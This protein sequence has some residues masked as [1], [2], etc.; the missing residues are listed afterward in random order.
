MRN[1]ERL[2]LGEGKDV[3]GRGFATGI[4]IKTCC[5]VVSM[6]VGDEATAVKMDALVVRMKPI[7]EGVDGYA[8]VERR[9][10]KAEW[11][12][13]TTWKFANLDGL[14]NYLG[15][16]G[17][18]AQVAALLEEAEAMVGVGAIHRQNFAYDEM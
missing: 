11:D 18:Q 8:G 10:C 6:N 1:R 14:K 17:K 15:D 2:Y 9:V 16:E 5:R 3:G 4:P 12:Y 7:M 13:A